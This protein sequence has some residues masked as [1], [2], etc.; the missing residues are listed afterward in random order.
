MAVL[1]TGPLWQAAGTVECTPPFAVVDMTASDDL[2]EAFE[3]RIPSDISVAHDLQQRI[4]GLLETQN[5]PARDVF[6]A[7]LALEEAIVNAIK[8]GNQMDPEK[9]VRVLCR[10]TRD[11][12]Y[13]EIED[14]GE[15]FDPEDVPD[16]T[17]DENLELPCGRGIMLMR[18]FMTFVEYNRQGTCVT[19]I[20]E[21]SPDEEP[22]PNG[23][24][25]SS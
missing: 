18:S 20:R 22:S 11:R 25:G 17:L 23:H 24:A 5:F 16:P 12:L 21:R 19:M 13:L 15:G 8:H 4:I 7:R 1:E 9:S 10:M 3:V 6:G 14:Q 2:I